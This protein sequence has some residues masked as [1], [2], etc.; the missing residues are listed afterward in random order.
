MLTQFASPEERYLGFLIFMT[1]TEK[2]KKRGNG[3]SSQKLDNRSISLIVCLRWYF[4]R[5]VVM[6]TLDHW[7]WI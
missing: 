3:I 7:N 4:S 1:F 5:L 2:D 6:K